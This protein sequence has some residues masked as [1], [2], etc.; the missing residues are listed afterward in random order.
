MPC[1]VSNNID[2]SLDYIGRADYSVL[3]LF[4]CIIIII[5]YFIQHLK[6]ITIMIYFYGSTRKADKLHHPVT[7]CATNER[8]AFSL[9]LINFKKNGLLGSPKLI[10]V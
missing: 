1:L 7:V 2:Y 9:A 10:A 4:I 8:R 5:I 3:P 6:L